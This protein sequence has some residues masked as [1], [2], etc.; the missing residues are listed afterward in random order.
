MTLHTGEGCTIT[1]NDA[2]SGTIGTSNCWTDAP[3]QEANAGCQITTSNTETYGSGFNANNG[4]V[5]ATEWTSSAISIFFFPRGSIPSDITNGSPEPSGWG[6]PMA[7][8]QGGCDIGTTFT[9][10]QIVFDTTFCGAWAGDAWSTGSCASQ[11]ATC[12]DY[13][14]NNPADFADAYWS[15]NA[16]QVY[17][18]S[19][20]ASDVVTS[21][22]MSSSSSSASVAAPSSLSV[23]VAD[24]SSSTMSATT[25]AVSTKSVPVMSTG[26]PVTPPALNATMTYSAGN[27]TN[28]TYPTGSGT[29]TAPIMSG[30]GII[31]S[32]PVIT[33]SASS[34]VSATLA[35]TSPPEI[36]TSSSS[37]AEPVTTAVTTSAAAG[38]SYGNTWSWHGHDHH[39]EP[40]AAAVKRHL[41]QHK[42]HGAGRL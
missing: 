11:A 1:N 33:A 15:V 5:Y 21:S 18:S 29:G 42:R 34:S 37:A 19:G 22:A 17:Q 16:L 30:T 28:A 9:N 36:L 31:G 3:D 39:Y 40:S 25:F 35:P 4:G 41:R 38:Q 2:F 20:T 26:S 7:Q 6:T 14:E 23:S 10:Q 13:V 12:N 27:A 32:A 8:F 24:N